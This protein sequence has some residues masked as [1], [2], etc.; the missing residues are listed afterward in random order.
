MSDALK[1][2]EEIKADAMN[3]LGE[4]STPPADPAKPAAEAPAAKA[5]NAEPPAP[6]A[7]PVVEP[8]AADAPNPEPKEGDKDWTVPGERLQDEVKK[9]KE[10]ETALAEEKTKR[11]ELE[12]QIKAGKSDPEDD[13][14]DDEDI[15]LKPE[16]L[17]AMKKQGFVTRA[18]AE[19]LA[20]ERANGVLTADKAATAQRVQAQQEKSELIKEMADKGYPEFKIDEILPVA[21]KQFGEKNLSKGA[22]KAAYYEKHSAAIEDIMVKQAAAKSSAPTATAER[23]GG[24][25][26]V[27]AGEEAAK[28]PEQ[29]AKDKIM[30][31]APD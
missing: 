6:A 13:P 30:A 31:L 24:A 7:E 8:P 29:V 2:P 18:E 9:R 4:P 16:V 14:E 22:L 1:T 23:P 25:P 10:I 3:S 19:K 27:G 11:E 20:E 5:A 15:E 17:K 21:T 28:T 12:A 26:K